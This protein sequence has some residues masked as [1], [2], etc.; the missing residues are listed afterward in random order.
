MI[1]VTHDLATVER[2]C[3]RA[4]LL[5]RGAATAIGQPHDVVRA[6]RQRDL[7]QAQAE[8]AL[9]GEAERWGDGSAEIAEAWFEDEEG[10]RTTEVLQG[11][12]AVFYA[13]IRFHRAVESP[14]FGVIIKNERREHVFVTNTQ[15]D[16][17]ETGVF[18]PGDECTYSVRFEAHLAD[19]HHTASP[20]VAHANAERFADW[21]D[22]FVGVVVRGERYTGGIVDLPHESAV[23]RSLTGAHAR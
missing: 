22:D 15:F 9:R 8:H 14:V 13:R 4:L 5:E 18:R 11:Q 7:D 20:A 3:D 10:E 21:R 1:Y 19:G 2:F 16:S 12:P 23:E 6:Y 17:V